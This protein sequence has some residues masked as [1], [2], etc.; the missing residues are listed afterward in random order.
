MAA[1][2]IEV[3]EELMALYLEQG[4]DLAPGTIY[5]F[6]IVGTNAFGTNFGADLV[7][8]APLEIFQHPANAAACAGG[9]DNDAYACD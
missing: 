6:R 2:T 8:T 7:F 5:H 4:E 1:Y 9:A 3:D